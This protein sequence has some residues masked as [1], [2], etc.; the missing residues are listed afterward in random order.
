MQFP[1][2]PAARALGV[3]PVLVRTALHRL[4]EAEMVQFRIDDHS[5]DGPRVTVSVLPVA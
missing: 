4:A 5:A 2:H 1:L 3:Q